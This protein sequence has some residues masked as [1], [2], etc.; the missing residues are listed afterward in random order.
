MNL[1]GDLACRKILE[2]G[3][4]LVANLS[5]KVTNWSLVC[6]LSSDSDF[7]V[8]G[9]RTTIINNTMFY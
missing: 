5:L 4:S 2:C 8:G 1:Y 9:G 6:V 7:S 3:R